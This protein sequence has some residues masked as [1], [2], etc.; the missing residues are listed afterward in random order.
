MNQINLRLA[1]V[2]SYLFHPLFM[3]SIGLFYLYFSN[4]IPGFN[5]YSSE[6]DSYVN[7]Q[8]IILVLLFSFLL[9]LIAVFFLK[10]NNRI[11]SFQMERKEE[12]FLPF[13]ITG[14]CVFAVYYLLFSYFKFPV[15]PL[16]QIFLVGCLFSIIIGLAI[17]L[18]WKVSVHMIG[19]GGFVGALFLLSSLLQKVL[20]FELIVGLLAAGLIAYSR[21]IL[22]AHDIS[23]I[24]VG[25]AVGF[26]C[27]TFF[28]FFYQ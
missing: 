21:L 7:K 19:I 10:K 28:L 17:T 16:V 26:F 12:R 18:R 20:I 27:E 24:A 2:I 9:P 5:L 15:N 23:Q 25:F 22:K 14:I 1:K 13:T 4:L 6:Q 3:P 8:V 11:Q